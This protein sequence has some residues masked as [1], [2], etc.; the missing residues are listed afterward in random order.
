MS[1]VH[2]ARVSSDDKFYRSLGKVSL[3]NP[4]MNFNLIN[5]GLSITGHDEADKR[6]LWFTVFG[7]RLQDALLYHEENPAQYRGDILGM[8]CCREMI[9]KDMSLS[10]TLEKSLE[11]GQDLMGDGYRHDPYYMTARTMINP[12]AGVI[13]L[14]NIERILDRTDSET[15]GKAFSYAVIAA[16]TAAAA[17]AVYNVAAPFF[18]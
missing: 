14:K 18:R 4:G 3:W 13:G 17:L 12:L 8:R 9:N 7:D 2:A 16:A 6:A 1:A 5:I 10:E 15:V 11:L